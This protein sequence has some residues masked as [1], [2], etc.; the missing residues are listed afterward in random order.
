METSVRTGTPSFMSEPDLARL[1]EVLG[2]LPIGIA[3]MDLGCRILFMNKALEELT[4]F[5]SLEAEGIPCHHVLRCGLHLRG[6]R[7]GEAIIAGQCAARGIE[8]DIIDRHRHKLPVR[9][10]RMGIR[11]E[12][13]RVAMYLEVYEDLTPLRDMER[14]LNDVS[15]VGELVSRGEAMERVKKVLPAI[16]QSDAPVLITGETGTGKDLA[17]QVI[18][19]VSPRS[20]G[21]FVRVNL[22]PMPEHLLAAELY[23]R[24]TA[25]GESLP[26]CFQRASGGTLYLSEIADLPAEHQAGLVRVLDERV[27]M[28]AGSDKSLHV[29]VRLVAATHKDPEELVRAGVLREDLFHRLGAVRL[30]LPSLRDRGEDVEFLLTHFLNRFASR[31]KKRIKGFSPRALRLLCAH[32]Y[33]GNVRELRN[34]V[35]YAVMICQRDMILPAHLPVHLLAAPGAVGPVPEHRASAQADGRSKRRT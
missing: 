22:G 35:E 8:T 25:G 34:I 13:G 10:S 5:T 2:G 6:F 31:F 18:H 3:A 20:R 19:K 15:G 29:D 21:P 14:R 16:A 24:E 12:Q 33:P 27:V 32:A 9:V 28:P 4:G 1:R 7:E 17:A 30:H 11:D 23:G 26:G